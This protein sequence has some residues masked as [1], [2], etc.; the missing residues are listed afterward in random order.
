MIL[1]LVRVP[2]DDASIVFVKEK[3]IRDI[4]KEIQA[5]YDT[6]KDNKFLK[7]LL[8][9]QTYKSQIEAKKMATFFEQFTQV[10]TTEER[11]FFRIS[12]IYTPIQVLILNNL[13]FTEYIF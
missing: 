13:E 3:V 9:P 4:E 12:I 1:D 5:L 7:K 6:V 2:V 8:T 11:Y 10:L